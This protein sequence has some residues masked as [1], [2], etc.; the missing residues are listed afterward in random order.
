MSAQPAM[1]GNRPRAS[2]FRGQPD[3]NDTVGA[4]QAPVLKPLH[5]VYWAPGKIFDYDLGVFRKGDF[6]L[7][8]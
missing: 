3:Q 4:F 5:D 6:K 2:G 8:H 7:L 1:G